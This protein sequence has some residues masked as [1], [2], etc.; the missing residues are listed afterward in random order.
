MKTK[1]ERKRRLNRWVALF[2]TF[3]LIGVFASLPAAAVCIAVG[4]YR[5]VPFYLVAGIVSAAGAW[6]L[7]EAWK[8][9]MREID[10]E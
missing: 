8:G 3:H 2:C 10:A 9:V 7:L 1:E 4:A 6:L 5:W